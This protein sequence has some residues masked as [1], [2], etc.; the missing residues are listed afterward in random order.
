VTLP[1][2]LWDVR[3]FFHDVVMVQM[4]QPFRRNALSFL[5][6]RAQGG[7]PQTGSWVTFLAAALALI[8][9]WVR[10]A[11]TPSGFAGGIALL[12][13]AFFAFAKQAFAGYY[14]FVLGALCLA[15][16]ASNSASP[17]ESASP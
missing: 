12:Y 11:R 8:P 17:S 14:Y 6:W 1:F 4:Q 7:G 3:S 15:I 9:I 13:F 16:A 5:A 10:G 2:F